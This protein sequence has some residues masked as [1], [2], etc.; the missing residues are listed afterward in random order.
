MPQNRYIY[1]NLYVYVLIVQFLNAPLD[2]HE[3][4][5]YEVTYHS[6]C[7]HAFTVI[8]AFFDITI[9][10]LHFYKIL[11]EKWLFSGFFQLPHKILCRCELDRKNTFLAWYVIKVRW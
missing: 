4:L 7:F 3:F 5:K 10:T 1:G 8:S 11:K 2:L 9:E 6:G